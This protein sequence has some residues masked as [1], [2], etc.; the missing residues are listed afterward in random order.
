MISKIANV[1][2]DNNTD[3]PFQINNFQMFIKLS[4]KQKQFENDRINS[5]I[6]KLVSEIKRSEGMLNNKKFID[7]AP[8]EKIELEQ[9][10]IKQ[11]K[12]ELQKLKEV[13][14]DKEK[15]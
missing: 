14:H 1:I 4:N 12:L 7:K 10:K 6:K 13:T 8:K 5:E 11:F 2:Y 9:E 3:A 15:Q